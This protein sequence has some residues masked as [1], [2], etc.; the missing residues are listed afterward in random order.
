MAKKKKF[1]L[2][3]YMGDSSLDFGDMDFSFDPPELKDDRK[4]VTKIKDGFIEGVKD[5]AVSASF[6]RDMVK[7]SLPQGYGSALDLTDQTASTLKS[8]YNDAEKEIK[9]VVKDLKRVTNRLMPMAEPVLPR[10]MAEKIKGWLS[11][12]DAQRSADLSAE[13]QRDATI[14]ATMA[15]IFQMQEKSR[16]E[17][18][19]GDDAADRLKEGVDHQRHLDMIGQLD[20][21]RVSLQ[22]LAGYNERIGS[23]FQRKS[24]ELQF[25]HYF[26]AVDL[27]E[28]TKKQNATTK[29]HL[30]VIEKNTAL[31][32]FVKINRS[33]VI[34]QTLRNKFADSLT[35]G[36]IGNR[37]NFLKTLGEK[38]SSAVKEKARGFADSVQMGLSAADQFADMR[39]MQQSMA[40]MGGG[41]MDGKELAGNVAGGLAT[42]AAGA[43]LGKWLRGKAEK[44]DGIMKWG[45]KLQYMSENAPQLATD[46]A[47][48]DKG[49]SG[50]FGGLVSVLKDSINSTNSVDN[51]FISDKAGS[52]Q[53]P[54]IFRRQTNKSITEVIPG[55][56]ARIHQEIRMLRTGDEKTPLLMYDYN[57][58]QF[59]DKTTI[60]KNL[61]DSLFS[62]TDKEQTD[63]QLKRVMSVL[64]PDGTKLTDEQRVIL[65]KK[66]MADNLRN[67]S[68]DKNRLTNEDTWMSGDSAKH[69]DVFKQLF[70]DYFKD[71][72]QN[73]RQLQFARLYNTLGS[74]MTDH[75]K[76]MQ[77]QINVGN[78]DL[79]IEMG[80]L[81]PKSNTLNTKQ[82]QAYYSGE[83][84]APTDRKAP[85]RLKVKRGDQQDRGPSRPSFKTANMGSGYVG[86]DV[87]VEPPRETKGYTETKIA[88]VKELIDAIKENSARPATEIINETLLRI[89]KLITDKSFGSGGGSGDSS[90]KRWFDKSLGETI[91]D[92]ASG[93]KNLGLAGINKAR[94]FGRSM[95]ERVFGAAKTAM[96]G[97]KDSFN[98]LRS[99]ANEAVDVYVKGEL[100][101]RM[102]AAKLRAGE[103]VDDATGKVVTSLK[104]IKGNVRDRMGN[105]VLEAS[106][107]KDAFIKNNFVQKALGSVNS[108]WGLLKSLPGRIDNQIP[109]LFDFAKSLTKKAAGLFFGPKDVYIQGKDSPVLLAVT[110][111]AGGYRSRVSGKIIEKPSDIDGPV[112]D[113]QG[114]IVL[115]AEQLAQGIFTADGKR[116][117]SGLSSIIGKAKELG[118]LAW[119]T[120]SKILGK[121]K[122]KAND[123]LEALKGLFSKATGGN[124]ISAGLGLNLF[125]GNSI[126]GKSTNT[127]N[128][129][130][131]NIR[132]VLN[133]R[134]PGDPMTFDDAGMEVEHGSSLSG[135]KNKLSRLK[136]K[137]H[138]KYDELRYRFGGRSLK[139]K[140]S[141]LKDG[142]SDKVSNAKDRFMGL[143]GKAKDKAEAAKDK[144]VSSMGQLPDLLKQIRDRLTPKKKHIVGDAGEDGVRDGSYEDLMRRKGFLQGSKPKEEEKDKSGI[145]AGKAGLLSG[146][147][148][149]FG[150]KKDKEEEDDGGMDLSDAK[151]GWDMLKDGWGGAKKLGGK[152]LGKGKGLLGKGAG[153]IGKVGLKG[154]GKALGLAGAAYGGYSAYQNVKA[155]NYGEAALDAGLAAGGVAMTGAGAGL[156]TGAGTA[157][158]GLAAGIGGIISAPVLLGAAAI[159]AAGVGAYY[160]YKYLTR[161]KLDA[162]NKYRYAQYGFKSDDTD[163]LQA[164][165]GLEDALKP[166]VIYEKGIAK[167]DD[168]KIEIKKMIESFDVNLEKEPDVKNWMLWFNNRFKPVYLT[169]LT[170]LHSI[171]PKIS[172]ADIEKLTPT[173]K[174]KYLDGSR[175]PDGPYSVFVSP[176]PSLD[177]LSAGKPEIEAAVA[178]FEELIKKEQKD[179]GGKE[180]TG[181]EL[182]ATATVAA[183]ATAGAVG[184]TPESAKTNTPISSTDLAGPA[185]ATAATVSTGIDDGGNKMTIQGTEIT[186]A[187]LPL[188][189]LDALRCVRFKT[190]GLK[191][192]TVEQVKNIYALEDEVGKNIVFKKGN[193]AFW[194]GSSDY[195]L[196][197]LGVHYGVHG[198]NNNTTYNWLS[199][200]TQR[201]MPTYLTYRTALATFTNKQDE[202]SALVVMKPQQA[203]DIALQVFAAQS[204]ANGGMSVWKVG[205][206]PWPDYEINM[207]QKSVDANLAGMREKV[208]D[209]KLD[210]A[211]GKID[212]GQSREETASAAAAKTNADAAGQETKP[213]DKP[214]SLWG[215]IKQKASDVM[216][217][218][219]N[220]GTAVKN[221]AIDA[222]DATRG[223]VN[224][225]LGREVQHPGKGTGGDINTLPK[226]EGKGWAKM[227]ELIYAVAKMVGVDPQLLASMAAIESNFDPSAKAGT[228]SAT[229]LFQFISGTWRTML[230]KYGAKYGIDTSVSATDPRANALMGAEFIREN[231]E[232]LKGV[233][234]RP[235]TDTDAYIAHFMG[236]GGAKKFLSADPNAVA[237]QVF[238]K[239]AQANAPIFYTKDGK[240]RTISE[241]YNLFT[242]RL[243]S[244]AKQLG[245]D[246]GGAP[247]PVS[248][249]DGKTPNPGSEAIVSG[250][251]TTDAKATDSMPT[252]APADQSA[253]PGG[254]TPPKAPAPAIPVSNQAPSVQQPAAASSTPS[255]G[256]ATPAPSAGPSVDSGKLA[257]DPS[258]GPNS[259][260]SLTEQTRYRKED[261]NS[262]LDALNGTMNKSL[263]IQQDQLEV[264]KSIYQLMQNSPGGKGNASGKAEAI[265]T[266]SGSG[267]STGS[268]LTKSP[269]QMPKPPVSFDKKT[270]W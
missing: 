144:A 84:F 256:S 160:G 36:L 1:E 42:N 59:N 245:V 79:L 252:A 171:D 200:F 4:P 158:T 90:H 264:L 136:D 20:S 86:E 60:S 16:L 65:G 146:L 240:P 92:A 139:N 66:L 201:F 216:T 127:T 5:T 9:P 152:V 151:A 46:W 53:D 78:R 75:R 268:N 250:K 126:G 40:E 147:L 111:K 13:Q 140:F 191:E 169:H 2:D 175:W 82:Q 109:R 167:I 185:A 96:Q 206:S 181:G 68:A 207:D 115:T 21:M 14:Q 176:F 19:Q 222:Y 220:A 154:A 110:M 190:Y 37:R 168:K 218:I 228:S 8:L 11:S 71:D 251:P 120:G 73:V 258:F 35:D 241:I 89:E 261:A 34:Q 85:Y 141:D 161:K 15:E 153:L 54:D 55:Y 194:E 62:K 93:A 248:G 112:L 263:G 159:A 41:G 94:A 119:N 178:E 69:A 270:D 215:S 209:Q 210:E 31:P 255:T 80:L 83:S 145:D 183:T 101:P 51:S 133:Y 57:S 102:T 24:L 56:L 10:A 227:K 231:M 157:L 38:L 165:F 100:Y 269:Q 174:K 221:A 162:M 143:F 63:E 113:D 262:G 3:D 149:K 28:E 214:T 197:K 237:A 242:D 156:L 45:N 91:G 99:K 67:D 17:E 235:L 32:E 72:N 7:K 58:N 50:L 265:E 239:E 195:L 150:R 130:L 217:G 27:L 22:Q 187:D 247:T 23:S 124:G 25:R 211:F 170:V 106:E 129:L 47:R 18:K 29:A 172:L 116:V 188:G 249:G 223:A 148:S 49:E 97:A 226:A 33:E 243:R 233:V 77:D 135:L 180:K 105:I 44:H 30:E 246:V 118:A 108:A 257:V 254:S 74:A 131:M 202:A 52:M 236:A 155:G 43:R 81:D 238:P 138:D 142:I 107:A 244:R 259:V 117:R 205:N 267:K 98:W 224:S 229:G 64:D 70:T 193:V 12:E 213:D 234:K 204:K 114:N 121:A 26:V 88:D 199:W 219:G 179:A 189:R 137:I 48:S 125:S 122:D 198:V 253:A 164:V 196:K 208:G 177:K 192:M 232:A 182:A 103:Y 173:D 266:P 166:G 134:L 104:D 39:E 260:K 6:I 61:F 163:H 225:M 184:L 186:G 203:L 230:R 95:E 76:L 132:D 123:A 87:H 212:S 128:H